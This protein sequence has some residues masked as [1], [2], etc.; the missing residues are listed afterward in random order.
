M[1][2]KRIKKEIE[3]NGLE[4]RQMI[5][6]K[7]GSGTG[8]IDLTLYPKGHTGSLYV[9]LGSAKE[10]PTR[11]IKQFINTIEENK[12][13]TSGIIKLT[14]DWEAHFTGRGAYVTPRRFHYNSELITEEEVPELKISYTELKEYYKKL[15]KQE[16]GIEG[17]SSIVKELNNMF[18]GQ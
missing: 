2:R 10:I 6:V 11:T 3:E 12:S 13:R 9:F 4:W 8:S 17:D 7:L 5:G 15:R 14:N 1:S 16:E 18:G